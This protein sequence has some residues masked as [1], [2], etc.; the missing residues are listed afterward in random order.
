MY[1]GQISRLAQS[2]FFRCPDSWLFLFLLAAHFH[3][4]LVDVGIKTEANIDMLTM[5]EG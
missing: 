2:R 5:G 3:R 1:W 4:E